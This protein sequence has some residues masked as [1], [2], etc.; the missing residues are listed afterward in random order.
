MGIPSVGT[1][2]LVPFPFANLSRH[3][4]RPALVVAHAEFNNVIVCQI[5]TNPYSS[6][7]AI[8]LQESDFARGNLKA[9]SYIRPDKLSTLETGLIRAEL[10][11]INSQKQRQ[12]KTALIKLFG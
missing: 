10:A 8:V 6:K 5:T 12:V 4:M 3:K 7:K 9:V 1:V 2:I 11:E